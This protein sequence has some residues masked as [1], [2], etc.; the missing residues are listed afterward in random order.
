M[1]A[2]GTERRDSGAALAGPA[3]GGGTETRGTEAG[4]GGGGIVGR[5]ARRAMPR[6]LADQRRLVSFNNENTRDYSSPGGAHR[7]AR[8]R[9][10]SPVGAN[11]AKVRA[12]MD[13]LSAATPSTS[14]VHDMGTVDEGLVRAFATD[15][16]AALDPMF[17]PKVGDDVAL[18]LFQEMVRIRRVDECLTVLQQAGR[19]GFHAGSRGEEAAILGAAV[20]LRDQDWIFPSSRE[21]GAALWRGMPLGAYVHHMFGNAKDGAKGRQMPDHFGS[22][23]ARFGS[24]S[25]PTGTQIS[26]ATGFAWAAKIKRDDVVALVYF[27]DGATSSADFHNGLNFAGVFKTPNVFFC[28]NN[29]WALS[30]P[31]ERQTASATLAV[32]GLA[33]GVP[34]VRV[35]GDDLFAVIKVTRDAVARAASGL[36]ATFIEA[37]ESGAGETNDAGAKS[38]DPVAR[39]RSYLDARSLWNDTK[40][41]ELEARIAAEIDLAVTAAERVGFP[42][43]E[44]MFDDVFAEVP[45]HLREQHAELL[46]RGK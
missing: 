18:T 43:V 6:N 22:R 21:F 27:G 35:D 15:D 44:T 29:G 3:E 42:A 37:L 9:R 13:S 25:S 23:V 33:Y 5:K 38:R 12:R 10:P 11:S 40:Q 7:A 16:D 2:G 20:G 31:V 36:G 41:A 17:D 1:D 19:I 28:R 14:P 39:M 8:H 24:I 30:V 34:F 26:H 32:K 46:A 45:P 4:P